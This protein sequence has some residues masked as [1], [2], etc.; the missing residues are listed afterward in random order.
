ME[1]L[2]FS[3]A[4]SPECLVIRYL[5]LYSGLEGAEA[6]DSFLTLKFL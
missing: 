3:D 5:L 6:K 4:V 2:Q 1:Y